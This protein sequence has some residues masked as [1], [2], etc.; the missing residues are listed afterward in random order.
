VR[1]ECIA[2][3]ER[4]DSSGDGHLIVDHEY[5]RISRLYVNLDQTLVAKSLT[6]HI[7]IKQLAHCHRTRQ[8]IR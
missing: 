1:H 3:K 4:R 5:C 6:G 8:L 2:A 7:D